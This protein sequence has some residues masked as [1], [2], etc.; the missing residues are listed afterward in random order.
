MDSWLPLHVITTIPNSA[1]YSLPSKLFV[2][3]PNSA[4]RILSTHWQF[5]K[6]TAIRYFF[7][8]ARQS[9]V[10]P[11]AD[12]M[13][14]STHSIRVTACV[15]LHEAGMDGT[16]IKLRLRWK[17]DCFEIYLRN[18]TRI[19]TQHNSALSYDNNDILAAI[20]NI[21]SNILPVDPIDNLVLDFSF[22]DL[23]DDD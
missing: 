19:T 3:L 10:I 8:P 23:I 11:S 5:I 21:T 16:Y 4:Q 14:I 2:W 6:T 13:L 22:P 20:T 12:L 18:T 9:P 1:L 17:S 15:L 7:L